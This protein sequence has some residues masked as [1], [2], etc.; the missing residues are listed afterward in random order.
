MALNAFDRV[1]V[2]RWMAGGLLWLLILAVV[3]VSIRSTNIAS[4][5]GRTAAGAVTAEKKQG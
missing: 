5:A 3:V 2:Y 4:R 1:M